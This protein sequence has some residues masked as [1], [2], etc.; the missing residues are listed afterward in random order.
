MALS[1]QEKAA[2]VV[3]TKLPKATLVPQKYKLLC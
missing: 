3:I 1:A 2:L